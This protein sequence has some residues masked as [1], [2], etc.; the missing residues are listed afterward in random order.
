MNMNFDFTRRDPIEAE[1]EAN[2]LIR[3]TNIQNRTLL[4]RWYGKL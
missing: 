1:A 4:L 2:L 3:G